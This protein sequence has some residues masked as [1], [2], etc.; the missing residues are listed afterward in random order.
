MKKLVL[1]VSV[2]TLVAFV[3]AVMA[4]PKPAPSNPSTTAAPAPEK[5]K[6]EKKAPA[7]VQKFSGTV[8]KVDEMGKTIVAKDKKGEKTFDVSN[9]KISR[10]GK[11][12]PLGE[13][14]T[15]M[16]ASI[17]YKMEGDKMMAEKVMV[18]APKAPAKKAAAK[19]AEKPK[20][21]P[22]APAGT[23]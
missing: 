11:E 2:L 7:K 5:A 10:A 13:M 14:K 9:A 1:L 6:P 20:P 22:A 18:S 12:L 4:Q 15:G 8:E 23:K 16:H 19:P 21:A 3:G 17:D